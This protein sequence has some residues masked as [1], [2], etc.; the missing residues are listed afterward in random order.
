[1]SID[2]RTKLVTVTRLA[3][4][5]ALVQDR[6]TNITLSVIMFVGTRKMRMLRME[7]QLF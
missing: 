5:Q 1:M 7:G 3:E 2:H 4:G 6:A